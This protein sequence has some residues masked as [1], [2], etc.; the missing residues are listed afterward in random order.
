M[1]VIFGGEPPVHGLML[2]PNYRAPTLTDR[3]QPPDCSPKHYHFGAVPAA[4]FVV[5]RVKN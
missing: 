5:T 1:I 2:I 3:L 4:Q